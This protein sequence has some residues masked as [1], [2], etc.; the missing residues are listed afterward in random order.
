MV[1]VLISKPSQHYIILLLELVILVWLNIEFILY[2]YLSIKILVVIIFRFFAFYV[3]DYKNYSL[4]EITAIAILLHPIE[5]S[6]VKTS[7]KVFENHVN[8]CSL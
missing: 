3:I 1:L 6:W 8:Y 7:V 4:M 5:L 2:L